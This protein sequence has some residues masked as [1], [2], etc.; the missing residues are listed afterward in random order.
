[1]S[2]ALEKLGAKYDRAMVRDSNRLDLLMWIMAVVGTP[3]VVYDSAGLYLLSEARKLE[4]I[5]QLLFRRG[6]TRNSLE[7][8]GSSYRAAD[9]AD[10][11]PSPNPPAMD[12]A[13]DSFEEE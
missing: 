3:G 7:I 4:M 13:A 12:G 9:K 11:V 5:E 2:D 10:P 8:G 6:I 1:M